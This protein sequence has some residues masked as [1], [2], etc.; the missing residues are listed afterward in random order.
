MESLYRGTSRMDAARGLMGHGWP[1]QA[2]PR[3]DDAM[4]EP[5]RSWGRMSGLD[6]LVTFGAMP[7]VTR[8]SERN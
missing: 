2:G 3:N 4:R 8:S 5:Q 7:K 1:F 6:L